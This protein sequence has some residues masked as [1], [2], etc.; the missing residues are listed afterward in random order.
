MLFPNSH[1][2]VPTTLTLALIAAAPA[3]GQYIAQR[4]DVRDPNAFDN[5]VITFDDLIAG[6]ESIGPQD[7]INGPSMMYIPDG[8]P[9]KLADYYLYFADHGGDHIKMAYG[10]S[11]TGPFTLYNP[12]D[13]V[14]TLRDTASNTQST[15]DGRFIDFGNG[16]G[17]GEHIASPDVTFDATTGMFNMTYHGERFRQQTDGSWNA[18]SQR[19]FA[20][21]STDGLNFQTTQYA[22]ELTAPYLREFEYLGD[23]YAISDNGSQIRPTDQNNPYDTGI[24]ES[25][26]FNR[27]LRDTVNALAGM[28]S[29]WA[30][31]P[32]N[33]AKQRGN[34]DPGF[35]YRHHA[36][37]VVDDTLNWF[38]TSRGEAPERIYQATIQL[39]P[40]W[41][42]WTATGV[43]EILRPELD[44]EGVN[45]PLV[46][47]TSGR[48][49]VGN[50]DVST[51]E[52]NELRDPAFFLD[53]VSGNKYL[54]YSVAGEYGIAVAE[55]LTEEPLPP[56]VVT[57]E[58]D[59]D[60]DP[61]TVE[62]GL[63][64]SAMTASG[65]SSLFGGGFLSEDADPQ[66]FE[67]SVNVAADRLL[68]LDGFSL[69]L[70][71]DAAGHNGQVLINGTPFGDAFT[72]G[73]T[74]GTSVFIAGQN[75][76]PLTDLSGL[77][78]VTIQFDVP[79]VTDGTAIDN[80]RLNGDVELAP[81]D[82][83]VSI[84]KFEFGGLTS[85]TTVVD[86][87][88]AVGNMSANGTTRFEA[89]GFRS[90]DV[91]PQIFEFIIE[92]SPGDTL[93]L[94]GFSLQMMA[95]RPNHV[96]QVFINGVAFGDTFTNGGLD[97]QFVPIV[98]QNVTQIL[99]LSGTVTVEIEFDVPQAFR[100]TVIDDFE[101]FGRFNN[102]AIPEPATVLAL[103]VATG[104]L[105]LRR[106]RA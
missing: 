85:P 54:Y 33:S 68:N 20:A 39:D 11:P 73:S 24:W 89:G 106:N 45:E 66:L 92:L 10:N 8:T 4:V 70:T 18:G 59:A 93:D 67:F 79:A 32:D 104:G 14:M 97:D 80:F 65:T 61:T 98:G 82:T 30:D 46:P 43:Y 44:Y 102:T 35:D 63:T 42:N 78:E 15:S 58:F 90:D 57:Y 60:A 31:D 7:S 52:K 94:T 22:T 53:P 9:N 84:V 40:D 81:V 76:T 72:N 64:A 91:D 38:F 96:G 25:V 105:G 48:P 99:G 88:I 19:S 1:R 86:P 71:A 37:E 77:V 101:L 26:V 103:L 100:D 6:G 87:A 13:G 47:S 75:V 28:E 16:L 2:A 49:K 17:V 50:G 56:A 12:N 69:D 21:F 51:G 36:V 34:G 41:R 95:D 23:K 3:F 29:T 55:L 62:D 74:V 27:E 83:P 5:R